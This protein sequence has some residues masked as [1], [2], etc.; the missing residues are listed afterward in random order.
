M[1]WDSGVLCNKGYQ[2]E[3]HLKLKSRQISLVDNICL[4]SQIVCTAHSSDTT[5]LCE[6]LEDDWVIE[7]EVMDERECA[8]FELIDHHQAQHYLR[9]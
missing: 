3:T 8:R 4:S 9:R 7:T 5:V 6:K 2:S 1:V